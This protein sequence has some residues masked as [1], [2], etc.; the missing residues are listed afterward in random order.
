MMETQCVACGETLQGQF[1]HRCGE[2]AFH[3]EDHSFKTFLSELVYA[4][5]H[6]DS[7]FFK[8]LWLLLLKPGW[9]TRA[10][11]TGKRKQYVKPLVLFVVGN[12]IYFFLQPLANI[13]TFNSTLRAQRNWFP[14]SP[15]VRAIVDRRINGDGI[16]LTEYEK[17]YDAKSEHLAKTLIVLQIPLFAFFVWLLQLPSRGYYFEHLIFS[18]H[19][20]AFL[21]FLNILGTLGVFVYF[22]LGG[23]EYDLAIPYL[24]ASLLY[25]CFSLRRVYEQKWMMTILKG[26]LLLVSSIV[27]LYIYRF[28]LFLITV[29][30]V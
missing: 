16:A 28:I 18:T 29:Y 14:Y 23:N 3:R 25:L 17:I 2:K 9:L 8:S 24:L 4:V 21:M 7:K 6:V 12:V 30:S 26:I 13:N 19:F 27:V 11:V 10:Y 20:Y 5:T 22:K 1:C 15:L